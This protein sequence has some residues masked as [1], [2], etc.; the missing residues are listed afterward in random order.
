MKIANEYNHLNAREF[1]I[2]NRSSEFEEIKRSIRQIDANRFL[3]ISCEIPK[4]GQV[5]YS[6][7]KINAAFKDLLNGLGWRERRVSYYVTDD[8]QTMRDIIAI[9]DKKQ[10][11]KRI[12]EKGF[13][14]YLSNNQV[15]FQK[16]RIAVEVQ[17][18]KYFSVAYDL[19][20]K[21]TFFYSRNDIDVGVEIIPTKTME[22]H[23]DTGV[24]WFENEVA[25]VIREGRTNP[26]VPVLMLGIE[27]DLV[28]S[29]EA[30]DYSDAEYMDI[31]RN[32]DINKAKSQIAKAESRNISQA[33]KNR[34][35]KIKNC[36]K[37]MGKWE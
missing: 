36:L 6:Q 2:V 9:H 31:L 4:L 26:P 15:D 18:G 30:V 17:F 5:F 16:E 3:K 14:A 37:I 24:P 25:N 22:E 23:M 19:H 33:A 29:R 11:K 28:Q 12:E 20:V 34:I 10:Q 35:D 21:H 32:S 13:Q 7:S 8:A 1:L 27:P